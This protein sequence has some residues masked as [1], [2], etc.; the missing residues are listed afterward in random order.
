MFNAMPGFSF[1]DLFCRLTSFIANFQ[2]EKAFQH[3]V[4]GYRSCFD[5]IRREHGRKTLCHTYSGPF[6]FPASST[7]Y[8]LI[9][10]SHMSQLMF[11]SF[12]TV[13]SRRIS[14]CKTCLQAARERRLIRRHVDRQAGVFHST[15]SVVNSSRSVLWA[16]GGTWAPH[17]VQ[18]RGVW[19]PWTKRYRSCGDFPLTHTG[20]LTCMHRLPQRPKCAVLLFSFEL[21]PKPFHCW[22]FL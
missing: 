3:D 19:L 12:T 6:L 4:I 10:V 11:V 1:L 14:F 15:A 22:M 20:T 7:S 17:A 18:T 16:V 9:K 2:P 13:L 21:S 5:M 8:Q